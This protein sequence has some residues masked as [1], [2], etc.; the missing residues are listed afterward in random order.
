MDSN[1]AR[2]PTVNIV[3]RTKNRELLLARAVDDVLSQ[4]FSDWSLTI[5]NDGGRPAAVDA[6]VAHRAS[7]LRGRARV[8]HNDVSLGMEAASNQGARSVSSEFVAV[9]DDDDSWGVDFLRTTVAWLG[10]ASSAPAVAVRTAIIWE[11]VLG[12]RVSEISREIFLPE[13][14]QV[15]LFDLLRFNTCVPISLLYRRSALDDVGF[16][17][18]SLGVGGDWECNLRLAAIGTIGFLPDVPLAYWH[19]RPTA[20]GDMGN[21]VISL[22]DA[23]RRMDRL[24]RDRALRAHVDADGAG[25]ALY[26]TRFIDDRFDEVRERLDRLE[27]SVNGS[28]VRRLARRIRR[29]FRR[30][31][32]R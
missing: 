10:A 23:H 7:A 29:V 2:S 28:P 15:T 1:P 14:Q 13:L 30:N 3:M 17:D 5:V 18:E 31:G 9:H 24:I 32:A 11:E 27:S 26:L 21:S 19:Q 16:F 20:D 4:S 12:G 8:L 25:L 22:N 6:I